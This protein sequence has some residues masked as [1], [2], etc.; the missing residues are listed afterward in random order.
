[1]WTPV[2]IY[3]IFLFKSCNVLITTYIYI[4]IYIYM[5]KISFVCEVT[6]RLLLSVIII[7]V[8]DIFLYFIL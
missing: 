1:M 3:I 2:L 8:K 7:D 6:S 5:Q 4:Y